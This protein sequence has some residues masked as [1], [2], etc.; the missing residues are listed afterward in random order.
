MTKLAVIYT[1]VSSKEQEEGGYSIPAQL[2]F[3]MDY[4][5]SKNLDVVKVYSESV[6]ASK[7]GRVEFNKML[8][9]AKKQRYGCHVIIEKNDRLLRNEDDEALLIKLAVKQGVIDLHLPKD[10][11]ILNRDSTP[12]EIFMFHMLCGMS[13]MY[14][15]NL[16]R[17]IKKGLDKKADLGDYPA[18][19]PIGYINLRLSKKKSKVEIDAVNAG[20]V[21]RIFELYATGLYSYKTLAERITKDGF[22]PKNKPCTKALIEKIII[23]P[24]YMGEFEYNGKRYENA[25]HT[26]IITKELFYTCKK[27]REWQAGPKKFTHDFLYAGLITC[28]QC[29][30]Q[31][32][33]EIKKGKYIYY[34]CTGNKGGDCK[35]HYLKE[36]HIDKI[37][38]RTLKSI[39]PPKEFADL[40]IKKF[41]DIVNSNYEYE[42]KSFDEI[43]KK[44]SLLKNRLNKLYMDRLD[45]M[46][47]DEFYIEK[48]REFQN[49][50]DD[51]EIQ[52]RN[53][54]LE[55]DM[56]IDMG[57]QIIELCKN[58][59]NSYLR[60]NNENK[61]LLL[62]IL[63]SNFLYDGENLVITLKNT[64]EPMLLGVN[65]NKCGG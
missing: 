18:R 17:E 56:L 58:A 37:V 5:K 54:T 14:P 64:L 21:S 23:N 13:C 31:L 55:N 35:R 2:D 4:A 11:L 6:T 36:E 29:G 57:V 43:N 8:N 48:K 22:C 28:S 30:C 59:Y 42:K 49:E 38:E 45:G 34:H 16:S 26:P 53:I 12:H 51:F 19:A 46:I 61:R 44:I 32:T 60:G 50:L 10:H 1:R 7:A 24:F 41:K 27:V 47:N 39:Q 25:S 62:K 52:H 65:F 33:A 3:L 40:T 9:F 15:R 20:Y 63:C